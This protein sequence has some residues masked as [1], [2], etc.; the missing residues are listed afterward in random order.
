MSS[1]ERLSPIAGTIA[2][3]RPRLTRLGR[4][5]VD[6]PPSA[7]MLVTHHR[8]RPGTMGRIGLLLGDAGVNIGQVHLARDEPL[9]DALMV[10]AVD[11]V[12]SDEVADRIRAGDS[13][14]D[15]WRM[16]LGPPPD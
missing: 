16:H 2:N 6:L 8:D 3:G 15:L 10:L 4:F 9:G 12:V 11:D 14:L 7:E 1:S 13:V 5:D